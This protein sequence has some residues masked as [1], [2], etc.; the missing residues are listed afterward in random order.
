MEKN[1][2]VDDACPSESTAHYQG[3]CCFVCSVFE[4]SRLEVKRRG[5]QSSWTN[6]ATTIFSP[7]PIV[8]SC[9]SKALYSQMHGGL[10]PS[11]DVALSNLSPPPLVFHMSL[12][13]VEPT[14]SLLLQVKICYL[15]PYV[16]ALCM[17][18]YL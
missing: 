8:C 3:F 13:M 18:L 15:G 7:H 1:F 16:T 5:I 14:S 4:C 17:L 10:Y 12:W 2:S 11:L 9:F 6:T